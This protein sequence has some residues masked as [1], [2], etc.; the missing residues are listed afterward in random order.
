MCNSFFAKCALLN[1]FAG[2]FTGADIRA[3]LSS[4]DSTDSLQA[5]VYIHL[6]ILQVCIGA[7]IGFTGCI[8]NRLELARTPDKVIGVPFIAVINVDIFFTGDRQ[9]STLGNAHLNTSQQCGILF[10]SDLSSGLNVDR[11]VVGNGKYIACGVDTHARQ[12]QRK[13]VQF[14]LTVH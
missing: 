12:L 4:V 2:A 5:A 6:G 13:G 7:V 1:I 9:V 11:D 14:R 3:A 10:N 8:S